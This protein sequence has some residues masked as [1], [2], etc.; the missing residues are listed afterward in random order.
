[1]GHGICY[2]FQF[3]FIFFTEQS[4]SFV[5]VFSSVLYASLKKATHWLRFSV[6]FYILH[7]TN[8]ISYGFQIRLTFFTDISCFYILKFPWN[9]PMHE[10]NHSPKFQHLKL[11]FEFYL[12]F[13]IISSHNILILIY[14]QYC[15]LYINILLIFNIEN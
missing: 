13:V 3:S 8:L 1:M 9:Q 10:G 4:Y 5:T 14:F 2:G 6:Q 7:W 12:T 15:I 11:C